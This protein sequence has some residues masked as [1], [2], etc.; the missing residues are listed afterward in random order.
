MGIYCGRHAYE[1]VAPPAGAAE[2]FD[3]DGICTAEGGKP[4]RRGWWL[5]ALPALVT[6][7][8][9]AVTH[10]AAVYRASCAV[11]YCHGPE[12]KAGRAPAL[13]GRGLTAPAI[14]AIAMSGIPN[15]S[16]PAF[17]GR[18]KPEEI[19][20][21]AA[22]VV[23]LGGGKSQAP[24]PPTGLKLPAAAE[25]GRALFF[26]AA[27]TGA[28]GSCHEVRERGIP[29]SLALNDLCKARLIDVRT[30]D[31]PGVLTVQPDSEPEFP[32]VV[33]EKSAT[34]LR[35]Y[36]LSSL[37]PVLRTFAPSKAKVTPGSSWRHSGPAS[38]YTD[39][40]LESILGF[41]RWAAEQ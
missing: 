15:T 12:G 23:S 26:D 17:G 2:R 7:A 24:G 25:H 31:T 3:A 11:P 40:E 16:M 27:R 1:L 36:D 32:A 4:M 5:F 6:A 10:G 38:L 41:L 13:A 19:E 8:D 18:L 30:I 21:V 39:A 34:R 20:G 22:Y 14:A 37:L 33:V 29:V 28:C 35:V 9:D